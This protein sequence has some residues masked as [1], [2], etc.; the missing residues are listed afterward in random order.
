MNKIQEVEHQ[1][2]TLNHKIEK[3]VNPRV[4]KQLLSQRLFFTEL[5]DTLT[6]TTAQK[7]I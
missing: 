4:S 7:E 5:L 2:K 6:K 1:I 3:E